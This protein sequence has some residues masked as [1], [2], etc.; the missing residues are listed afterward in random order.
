[1]W[2][3]L[4]LSAFASANS[5]TGRMEGVVTSGLDG[6][7]LP[8]VDVIL[9]PDA[10]PAE[11]EGPVGEAPLRHVRTDLRGAFTFEGLA[12]GLYALDVVGTLPGLRLP[13]QPEGV[14]VWTHLSPLVV[15][16][17]LTATPHVVLAPP[18]PPPPPVP[19]DT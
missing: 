8:N 13:G 11:G 6:R 10:E 1:M 12:P 17:G 9:R 4:G 3:V 14:G 18:P 15:V 19:R 16:P 2:W 5:A 7:S